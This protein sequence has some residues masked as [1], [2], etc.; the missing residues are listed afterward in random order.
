MSKI[1]SQKRG[2]QG[3]QESKQGNKCLGKE[4][5][6]RETTGVGRISALRR[7]VLHP[8]SRTMKWSLIAGVLTFFFLQSAVTKVVCGIIVSSVKGPCCSA[9]QQEKKELHFLEL[10]GWQ[11]E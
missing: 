7:E 3:W 4:R 10:S 5:D 1:S 6:C 8:T 2:H 9:W 11:F